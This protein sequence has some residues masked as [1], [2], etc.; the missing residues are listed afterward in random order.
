MGLNIIQRQKVERGGHSGW[1]PPGIVNRMR[2]KDLGGR[3]RNRGIQET[4]ELQK[5]GKK[6]FPEGGSGP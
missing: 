2:K 3:Q 4:T 6:M 1:S 5:S